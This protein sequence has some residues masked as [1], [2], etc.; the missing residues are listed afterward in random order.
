MTRNL[1]LKLLVPVTV[2]PDIYAWGAQ[3]LRFSVA[4]EHPDVKIGVVDLRHSRA[5]AEVA[6]E[7][8]SRFEGEVAQAMRRGYRRSGKAEPDSAWANEQTFHY[9]AAFLL[10]VEERT[11]VPAAFAELGR[12][13]GRRGEEVRALLARADAALKE[14]L[15]PAP[16]AALVVGISAYQFI[17]MDAIWLA[18]RVRKLFPEATL[19][20][21]GDPYDVPTAQEVIQGG[22]VDACVVGPGELALGQI[23]AAVKAGDDVRAVGLPRVVNEAFLADVKGNLARWS[24]AL[25]GRSDYDA[26]RGYHG[27]EWNGATKAIQVLG[28][29]GCT[30]GACTFC[31]RLHVVTEERAF[32]PSIA[33]VRREIARLMEEHF[34]GRLS[35]FTKGEVASRA[36]Y[37]AG[38][39]SPLRDPSAPLYVRFDADDADV[40]TV[41]GLIAWLK[42]RVPAGK[43]I[44][45][46]SYAPIRQLARRYGHALVEAVDPRRVQVRMGLPIESLNPKTTKTMRKGINPV[47]AAK[48]M[49]VAA[50]CG[51]LY[52][53]IY[54]ASYPLESLEDV[55]QECVNIDRALHLLVGHYTPSTYLGSYRD[56]I[57]QRP[58]RYQIA[59]DA[60]NDVDPLMGLLGL[61]ARSDS[62]RRYR[63]V[64]DSRLARLQNAYISL[65][66][67]AKRASVEPSRG[68]RVAAAL[69]IV[70]WLARCLG[71]MAL[72]GDFSYLR[73]L[74]LMTAF[75]VVPPRKVRLYLRGNEVV[76][77]RPWW[78]GGGWRRPLGALEARVLRYLYEQRRRADVLAHFGDTA[79]VRAILDEFSRR[80]IVLEYG[81]ILVSVV[82]DPGGLSQSVR[83]EDRAMIREAQA[84]GGD[85]Q[86]TVLAGR[87][88]RQEA[89]GLR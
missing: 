63:V 55:R 39:F 89:V 66:W 35:A 6:L 17:L 10:I 28:R 32:D 82:C 70:G 52:R 38:R 11:R 45:F 25:E 5:F 40:A 8:R 44:T 54:F 72:L 81:S 80:G 33:Q 88:G 79:E 61:R 29:R 60:R 19:V 84:D 22:R 71:H 9:L 56:A 34:A 87:T 58:G 64:G 20:A 85:E 83:D 68:Q 37:H 49:K 65:Y 16:G 1:E 53:G 48:A 26:V 24:E 50:D 15:Q 12:L 41:I 86:G 18:S 47:D 23:L 73:R 31:Q 75:T 78:L 7:I 13:V 4:S 57:G 3:C 77:E 42:A 51:V 14:L 74:L 62:S 43:R 30:W 27:V 69:G 36:L 46:Y 67:A 76:R 59:L 21:G 2:H